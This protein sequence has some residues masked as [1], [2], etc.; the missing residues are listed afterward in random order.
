MVLAAL[1]HFAHE[2][3]FR[4]GHEQRQQQRD[5]RF[6]QTPPDESPAA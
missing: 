6:R 2:P 4:R 5:P 3:R 1:A